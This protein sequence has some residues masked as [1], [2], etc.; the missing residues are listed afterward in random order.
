MHMHCANVQPDF[1]DNIMAE[2]LMGHYADSGVKYA[3][4]AT[5]WQC[6]SDRWAHAGRY[7]AWLCAQDDSL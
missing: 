5:E 3:C 2:S 1:N 7:P 4:G 6:T